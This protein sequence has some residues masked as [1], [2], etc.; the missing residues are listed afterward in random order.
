MLAR[1]G[2]ALRLCKNAR[3]G[4]KRHKR[5][6]LK[7]HSCCDA[8]FYLGRAKG[9]VSFNQMDYQILSNS[10]GFC[11]PSGFEMSSEATRGYYHSA[12]EG[13]AIQ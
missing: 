11:C 5:G 13:D 1:A 6:S 2:L 12:T 9:D 8:F 4:K 10:E 3:L 7:H